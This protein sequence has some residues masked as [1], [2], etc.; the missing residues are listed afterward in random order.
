MYQFTA[1]LA[2]ESGTHCEMFVQVMITP[3]CFTAGKKMFSQLHSQT[4]NNNTGRFAYKAA[5]QR[6]PDK[7]WVWEPKDRRFI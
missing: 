1:L 7:S 4:Q 2:L 6:K 5:A 3:P